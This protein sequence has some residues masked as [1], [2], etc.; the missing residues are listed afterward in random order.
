MDPIT[1]TNSSCLHSLSLFASPYHILSSF[2][3][4][5]SVSS[6]TSAITPSSPFLFIPFF[7]FPPTSPFPLPSFP[8][9][10]HYSF[11]S[12]LSISFSKGSHRSLCLSP[13]PVLQSQGG[14]ELGRAHESRSRQSPFRSGSL[15]TDPGCVIPSIL[16][17]L[18][19]IINIPSCTAITILIVP[20]S[21]NKFD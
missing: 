1:V 3:P 4:Y 5:L 10:P 6:P 19:F 13:H 11:L 16:I 21:F 12:L 2:F 14:W 8:S 18:H 9:L 7:F 17:L 15:S 20:S